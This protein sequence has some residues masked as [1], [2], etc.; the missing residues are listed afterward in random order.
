MAWTYLVE[1]EDSQSPYQIGSNQSPI[2]KSSDMLPQSYFQECQKANY[3]SHQSGM[4]SQP[5]EAKCCQK[6]TS[7]T[8][9]SH[10]RTSV[11]QEMGKA[12]QESEADYFSRSCA[13]SMKYNRNSSSWRMSQQSLLEDLAKSPQKLPKEAMI[14]DG[15][16]YPL[17][18]LERTISERDGGYLPTPDASARG[19]TKTYDPKCKSQSGRTLQSYAA[20]FPTPV[21]SDATTGAIIGKN[22]TF[23]MLPSGALRKIAQTGTDGSIG[24]ARFVQFFPTPQA[25]DHRNRGN[26]NNPS[27]QRRIKLGKQIGLTVV[28]GGQLNPTWVEWLMGYPLEWTGLKDWAMQ[29]CLSKRGKRSKNLEVSNAN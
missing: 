12:W 10:A 8:E 26:L 25:S 2:V 19:P 18:K 27:V 15:Q 9:D 20:M 17:L 5:L 22:D 3:Q 7:S 1:S 13:L 6:S 29:L 24:L 21:Q 28:A 14:V 4:M 23:K 16:L 11:L